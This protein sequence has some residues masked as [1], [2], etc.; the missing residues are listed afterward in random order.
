MSIPSRCRA[1][2]FDPQTKSLS[3]KDLPVAWPK[4]GEAIVQVE[5]TTL[6]AAEGDRLGAATALSIPGYESVGT[7]L[8]LGDPPPRAFSG[9]ALGKGDRVIWSRYASCG[10]CFYC[11][12]RMP[13]ECQ[14]ILIYGEQ[15]VGDPPRLAGGLS[16][17]VHLWP[18]TAI[19]KVPKSLPASF[20]AAIPH[21]GALAASA[22][23]ALVSPVNT[24]LILGDTLEAKLAAAM[25]HKRGATV[26]VL[27]SA[28]AIHEADSLSLDSPQH[29]RNFDGLLDFSGEA[30]AYDLALRELHPGGSASFAKTSPSGNRAQFAP[31][32]LIQKSIRFTG[33]HRYKAEHLALAL[34]FT[35]HHAANDA[36]LR[37]LISKQRPFS[38]VNAAIAEA[39]NTNPMRMVFEP[40]ME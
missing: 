38:E 4:A 12:R 17:L 31:H 11:R 32:A 30:C 39:M 26:D 5:L 15:P 28:C 22:I 35:I 6:D 23:D 2:V 13:Q 34:D 25:L 33:I 18:K 36:T 21:A 10:E 24:A 7:I 27:D 3:V 9:E 37:A 1:V 40:D 29:R 8:A 20:A 19:F 16:E 14:S